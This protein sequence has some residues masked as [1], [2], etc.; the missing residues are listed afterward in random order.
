[1][2]RLKMAAA[3]SA[4]LQKRSHEQQHPALAATVVFLIVAFL[5]VATRLPQAK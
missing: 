2:T 3:V 1:M 4:V 5:I